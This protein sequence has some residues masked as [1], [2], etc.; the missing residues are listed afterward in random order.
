MRLTASLAAIM[1][2]C[3]SAQNAVV[4]FLVCQATCGLLLA[5]VFALNHNG[6]T[7]VSSAEAKGIDFYTLQ[8]ITGRDVTP[9]PFIAW[10]AG[11]LNY[12]IEHHLFP[13]LPRHNFHKV[14]PSLYFL[15]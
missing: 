2:L 11:G 15:L 7:V 3:F 12:Q 1:A 6:M 14:R 4:F 13:M 9:T 10:F 5:A 8:I